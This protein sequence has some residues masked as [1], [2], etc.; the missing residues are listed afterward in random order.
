[1][2]QWSEAAVPALNQQVSGACDRKLPTPPGLYSCLHPM[3]TPCT[4]ITLIVTHPSDPY[5]NYGQITGQ[6]MLKN[7]Y[8]CIFMEDF[9]SL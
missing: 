1:M 2:S 5:K 6:Y 8:F 3:V 9:L 4:P 7:M